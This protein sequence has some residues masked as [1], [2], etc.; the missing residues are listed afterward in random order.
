MCGADRIVNDQYLD[1]LKGRRFRQTLLCR[2]AVAPGTFAVQSAA[3]LD[4]DVSGH[5]RAEP[6]TGQDPTKP[7]MLR[8]AS[9]D[10]ASISTNH[11]VVQAALRQVADA[12]PRPIR[13]EQLLAQAQPASVVPASAKP[14]ASRVRRRMSIFILPLFDDWN[15]RY[16]M[17]LSRSGARERGLNSRKPISET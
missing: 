14:A 12:F 2:V 4:L 10:G 3:V 16:S 9:S 17:S 11:P 15:A 8:F 1:F 13:V 7:G 6:V 5:I